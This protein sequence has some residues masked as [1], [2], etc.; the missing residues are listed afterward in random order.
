M[1]ESDT[2][3]ICFLWRPQRTDLTH[4]SQ[5][6]GFRNLWSLRQFLPSL[7]I[8]QIL[9]KVV[10]KGLC[11]TNHCVANLMLKDFLKVKAFATCGLSGSFSDHANHME[12]SW[13]KV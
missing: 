4:I 13:Q 6:K 12:T 2:R 10:G 11:F 8:M 5:G 9:W 1:A 7:V 3:Q